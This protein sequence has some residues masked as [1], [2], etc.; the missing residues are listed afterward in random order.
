MGLGHGIICTLDVMMVR[1][2]NE[3]ELRGVG[4]LSVL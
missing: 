3:V 1:I 4:F 2:E